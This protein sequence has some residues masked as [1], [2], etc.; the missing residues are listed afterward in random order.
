MPKT[1]EGEKGKVF[2]NTFTWQKLNKGGSLDLELSESH[3][4][5]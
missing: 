2:I 1:I 3:A 4:C 5:H